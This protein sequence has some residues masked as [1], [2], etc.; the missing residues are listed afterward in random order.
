MLILCTCYSA[1]SIMGTYGYYWV[2]RVKQTN[3]NGLKLGEYV[4]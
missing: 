4:S 2:Y 1:S 3:V